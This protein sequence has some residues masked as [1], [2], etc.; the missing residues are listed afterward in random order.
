MQLR[1]V[2][3]VYLLFGFASAFG[4]RQSAASNRLGLVAVTA[5]TQNAGSLGSYRLTG[6]LSVSHMFHPLSL[7]L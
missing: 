3:R 7:Y 4:L 2:G 6:L 5:V 1:P